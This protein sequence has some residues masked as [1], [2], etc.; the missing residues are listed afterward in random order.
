MSGDSAAAIPASMSD[1]SAAAAVPP[2]TPGSRPAELASLLAARLCHDFISPASAVVSGLDLLDDP[3]AQDMREDAMN[4]IAASAR[5]L[6]AMLAFSRVAFGASS[7][8]ETFDPRELEKLTRGV[9]EHVRPDLEWSV[10]LASASKPVARALLNIAQIGGG[11][12]PSGGLARVA[13][14]ERG[15]EVLMGVEASGARARLRPEMKA[16]LDGRDLESGLAGQWVQGFYLH[17]IVKAAGGRLEH[18]ATEEKVV[19]RARVPI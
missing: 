13:A 9:F 12:L 19:V 8:A 4:L 6:V 1:S 18:M 16:G 5:K 11:A 17:Q 7:S 14:Y 2:P 10:Q 3:S 15:G